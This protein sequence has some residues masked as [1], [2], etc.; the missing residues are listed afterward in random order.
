MPC[1]A[2]QLLQATNPSHNVDEAGDWQIG[3]RGE[4]LFTGA[5][6]LRPLKMKLGNAV[7]QATKDI[8]DMTVRYCFPNCS[9][10]TQ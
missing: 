6:K 3:L 1:I 7:C 10:S 5:D 9:E 4:L 8:H 2:K